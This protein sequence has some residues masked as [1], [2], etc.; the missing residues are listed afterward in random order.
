MTV[1]FGTL[2]FRSEALLPAIKSATDVEKIVFYHDHHESSLKAKSD[3]CSYC[4]QIGIKAVP[5]AVDDA[6]DFLLVAKRM[7]QDVRRYRK[8]GEEIVCFNIA[9]GT[10][11]MS[12]AA[13]LVSI[14]EGIPAT[15]VHDKT[16]Q[17]FHLPLLRIKYSETLTTKQRAILRY[18]LDH[19]D[20]EFS[21]KELAGAVG[22]EKATISHHVS[23]LVEKG[24][25]TLVPKKGDRRMKIVKVE[26]AVE[27]LLE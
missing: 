22:V 5:I 9:G 3:V 25:V 11:L 13:L 15:Y 12:S 20:V 4:E 6:F 7:K 27:L 1:L 17:P 26:P 23:R 18:I 8:D 2:G 10:K 19:R 16:L 14:L 21:E 24:I